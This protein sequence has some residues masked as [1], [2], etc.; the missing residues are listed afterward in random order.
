[1]RDLEERLARHFGTR[2]TIADNGGRGA[3][4]I[5]YGSLDELDRILDVI[6]K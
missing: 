4:E 2:V 3:M 6:F 5:R 1:M